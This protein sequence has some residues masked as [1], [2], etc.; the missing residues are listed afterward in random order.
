MSL[1]DAKKSVGYTAAEFIENGMIVGLGSGTTAAFFIERLAQRCQEGLAIRA[2]SSSSTSAQLAQKSG[3]PLTDINEV[4]TIDITVDGADEIDHQKRMIKGGGGAFVRE[5]IVANMSREMVVII[6]ESKLVS[7]LGVQKLPV[8]ILPFA[9]PATALHLQKLGYRGEWRRCS[10][11]S[12]YITDNN[13]YIFDIQFVK[14]CCEPEIEHETI[15]RI[16]GVVDTGFFFN[17]A[18]RIIIGFAD[19]GVV[20][21]L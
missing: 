13:N 18:G 6:D 3:V 11:G 21:R 8:E 4:T 12:L 5:K 10:N 20:I 17:L 16:P 7:E 14:P 1:D 2:V 19:G 9:H 15:L